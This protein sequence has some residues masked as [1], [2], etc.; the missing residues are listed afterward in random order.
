MRSVLAA[1]GSPVMTPLGL[2]PREFVR[3]HPCGKNKYAARM[4]HPLMYNFKRS[5]T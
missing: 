1:A 4:G 5:E 3:S 2:C